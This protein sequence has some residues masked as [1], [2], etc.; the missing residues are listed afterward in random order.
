M[1]VF[2]ADKLGN[3]RVFET[4]REYDH[5]VEDNIL[6]DHNAVILFGERDKK[7]EIA[8]AL[9]MP[10]LRLAAEALAYHF[11]IKNK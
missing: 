11:D 1:R 10:H 4:K 6:D 3:V 2:F 8:Y 9:K 5:A 7:G